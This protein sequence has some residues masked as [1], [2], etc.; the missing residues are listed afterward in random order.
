MKVFEVVHEFCGRRETLH[1]TSHDS[2]IVTVTASYAKHC[3]EYGMLLVGVREV[4]SIAHHIVPQDLPD[5]TVAEEQ[6]KE[7]NEIHE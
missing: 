2:S 6:E 4:L 3:E 7:A 1:I 5:E